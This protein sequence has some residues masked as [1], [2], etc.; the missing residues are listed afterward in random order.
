MLIRKR[1]GWQVE[2]TDGERGVAVGA[3]VTPG[4]KQRNRRTDNQAERKT[5]KDK[6]ADCADQ[7]TKG[8]AG[9]GYRWRERRSSRCKSHSRPETE[10]QTDRQP[11]TKTDRQTGRPC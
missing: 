7:K 11:S 8:V 10:N 4:Q 6:Q 5:Q 3:R 2:G 9:G 1:K